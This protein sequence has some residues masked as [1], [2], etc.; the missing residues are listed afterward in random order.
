M[1]SSAFLIT[2]LLVVSVIAASAQTPAP[3]TAPATTPGQASRTTATAPGQAGAPRARG[4]PEETEVWEPLPKVIAPGKTFSDAPSDAT[5]LFDGKD[6]SQ[7]V[8]SRDKSEAK[9]S[10]ADGN[11]TVVSSTGGIQTKN[12]FTNYQLHIEFRVPETVTGEGQNR[13][14]S[15]I[16]LAATRGNAGG[17][18][19]QVLDG[20]N[21]EN[22]TYVNGMVGSMYKE[23]IPLANPA[24]KKGEWN[25]YDIVWTAPTFHEDGT[26]KTRARITAFLNGVLVQNNY[27]LL[28]ETA[29]IG[30]HDYVKGGHGPLPISLQAHGNPV[31]YRNIWLRELKK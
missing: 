24:R 25:V 7:W 11:F 31:S 12:S 20:Y 23:S 10:V 29:F 18:E 8:S 27:E 13:G 1:K 3:T 19:I 5:I 21:N 26:V 2:T 4:N 9:W 17:Y 16:F 28:G 15:G 6:L 14:N 22:K 30:K